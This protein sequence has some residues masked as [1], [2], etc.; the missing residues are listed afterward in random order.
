MVDR[1]RSDVGAE[2][3]AGACRSP[4]ITISDPAIDCASVSPIDG[5]P[6]LTH[7]TLLRHQSATPHA[8]LRAARLIRLAGEVRT[9]LWIDICASGECS[10]RLR[11]GTPHEGA[12]TF[13]GTRMGADRTERI[14]TG[15][16]MALEERGAVYGIAGRRIDLV[17]G[18]KQE[19]GER[20]RQSRE[21]YI[22]VV[23]EGVGDFN[24]HAC[25]RREINGSPG[26]KGSWGSSRRR[27]QVELGERT[28]HLVC[29]FW[30]RCLVTCRGSEPGDAGRRY[31]M[32]VMRVMM[33]VLWM[34]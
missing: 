26:G 22:F 28:Q 15:K 4:E 17:R 5:A 30:L 25:W 16:R 31:V 27:G 34:M 20:R 13:D 9:D 1:V 2:S 19:R 6:F 29:C 24:M 8:P 3:T 11:G 23:D 14:E 18:M 10:I 33:I 32:V 7:T 21:G 12:A